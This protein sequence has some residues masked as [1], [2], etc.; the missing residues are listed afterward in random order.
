V[1]A[2]RRAARSLPIFENWISKPFF[3]ALLP[4][5]WVN[6]PVNKKALHPKKDERLIFRGTTFI[7]R[8]LP[9]HP[10]GQPQKR[11]G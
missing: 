8:V 10:L 4:L 3:P 11:R 2:P 5:I 6:P 9:D 7:P 1:L